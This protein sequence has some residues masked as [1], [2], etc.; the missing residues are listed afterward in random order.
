MLSNIAQLSCALKNIYPV[1]VQNSIKIVGN[2]FFFQLMS[3]QMS[4]LYL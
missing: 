1:D 4:M 2:H 3:H